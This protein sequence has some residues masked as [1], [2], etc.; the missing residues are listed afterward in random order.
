MEEN[1]DFAEELGKQREELAEGMMKL[2]K[3]LYLEA[4][5]SVTN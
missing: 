4:E 1:G 2:E 3:N 5:E